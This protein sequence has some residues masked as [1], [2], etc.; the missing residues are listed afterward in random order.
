MFNPPFQL[1]QEIENV[2]EKHLRVSLHPTTFHIFGD[3]LRFGSVD[4]NVLHDIFGDRWHRIIIII[5]IRALVPMFV[6]RMVAYC[7]RAKS[8]G[9]QIF[10]PILGNRGL[11]ELVLRFYRHA[12]LY[13]VNFTVRDRNF[14]SFKIIRH[15][16]IFFTLCL[17]LIRSS[18]DV[19]DYFGSFR[20]LSHI[21]CILPLIV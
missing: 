7:T 18:F 16:L 19:L 5:L 9:C 10:Q 3:I 14:L 6:L 2:L 20:I 1:S 4:D 13:S 12:F 8:R 21:N 11:G 15:L 17:S